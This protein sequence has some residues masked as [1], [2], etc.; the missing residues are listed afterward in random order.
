[1]KSMF[2]T[3]LQILTV[4][5]LVIGVVGAGASL[6]VQHALAGKAGVPAKAV[7]APLAQR[8]ADDAKPEE[9]AVKLKEENQKLRDQVKQLEFKYVK[10]LEELV[11]A[12]RQAALERERAQAEAE[13]ARRTQQRAEQALLQTQAQIQQYLDLVRKERVA[14]AQA[15]PGQPAAANNLKLIGLAF[16]QYYDQHKQFPTHAIYSKDG[17]PLLSWRVAVLPYLDQQALYQQF[18]LDEPWDSEHNKTLLAKM[19]NVFAPVGAQHK[20]KSVTFIQVFTGPGTIFDGRKKVRLAEII[21]GTS[22]TI[23]AVEGGSPVPWTKPE[24][25]VYAA[26]K[27]LPKLGGQF[28]GDFHIL[29]ADGS[30]LLAKKNPEEKVLRLAIT[31]ADG[32]PIRISD[33]AR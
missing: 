23:L 18:K 32:H 14:L 19:P 8:K 30:V 27:P 20:D 33:L 7:A 5:L 2:L 1:M 15:L 24:D 26:D 22:N 9:E 13:Q 12:R 25:L 3:K 17:Q 6:V 31:C 10:L 4:A 29:L 16:H 21:D 11:E 28:D